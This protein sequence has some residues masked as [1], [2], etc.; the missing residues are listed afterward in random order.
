[1]EAT[2]QIPVES[3]AK[4]YKALKLDKAGVDVKEFY[5]GM[6]HELEHM[7]VIQ[8]NVKKL[9]LLVLAHLKEVPDYYTKLQSVETNDVG[10]GQDD[11]PAAQAA[12]MQAQSPAAY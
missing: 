2:K 1:M 5:L 6:N 8:G 7:D 4:L 12:P 9:T 3:I 10:M 11:L